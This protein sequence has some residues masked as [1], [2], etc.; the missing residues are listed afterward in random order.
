MKVENSQEMKY[1]NKFVIKYFKKKGFGKLRGMVLD[2]LC[3]SAV[4]TGIFERFPDND[5]VQPG[6]NT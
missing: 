6:I 3:Y 5:N 1:L 4:C 2:K